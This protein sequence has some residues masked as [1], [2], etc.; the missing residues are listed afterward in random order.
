MI[1]RSLINDP[2]KDE[3]IKFVSYSKRSI[4][5]L[6]SAEDKLKKIEEINTDYYNFLFAKNIHELHLLKKLINISISKE[7]LLEI[8]MLL[9]N[10]NDKE[11]KILKGNWIGILNIKNKKPEIRV[12]KLKR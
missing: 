10:E 9:Y 1:R 7:G 4:K 12:A 11:F 3:V 2:V 5:N 6:K 8:G